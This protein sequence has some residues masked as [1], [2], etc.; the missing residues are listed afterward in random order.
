MKLIVHTFLTLD[1]VMQ[2]PGGA[3]ED[4]S[5]GFD[6]GGWLVPY[7][8][9]G[10]GEVVNGWFER[11]DAFLLG[12]TTYQLMEPYWTQ[13]DD[14][15]NE[16]AA[17]LN[18]LPKF[19]VS[20]TLRDPSWNAS[21]VLSGDV[22]DEVAQLKQRPGAELQVHGSWRLASTLHEAGLVDEYRLLVFPVT[23]GRGKRLFSDAAPARGY[24][25]VDSRAT[26]T[27]VVYSVLQPEPFRVGNVA[28]EEGREAIRE[29]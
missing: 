18:G 3:E 21:T 13:V 29:G 2:G 8:D 9:Q 26:S 25:L 27:G 5:D 24:T 6:R 14:P 1:G 22:L 23:V 12:R 20:S 16:V 7:V 10:F 4:T 19:V 11:A 28:V 17:K 15:A